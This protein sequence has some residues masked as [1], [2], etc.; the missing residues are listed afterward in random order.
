LVPISVPKPTAPPKP[1]VKG[2]GVDSARPGLNGSY[3]EAESK[4][5]TPLIIAESRADRAVLL[6][7]YPDHIFFDYAEMAILKEHKEE[8]TFALMFKRVVP[9][10][11][12]LGIHPITETR[13]LFG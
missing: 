7:R 4:D 6:E 3:T 10:A 2:K 8:A 1:P 11:T 5:G 9:D 13:S 12:V